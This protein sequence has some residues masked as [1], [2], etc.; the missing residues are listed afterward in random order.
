MVH[1]LHVKV[2]WSHYGFK[3]PGEVSNGGMCVCGCVFVC[4]G[5]CWGVGEFIWA[6]IC[7]CVIVSSAGQ[8]WFFTADMI[9]MV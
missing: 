1:K 2:R 7:M 4:F 9:T 3:R 5:L 6:C 8:Y